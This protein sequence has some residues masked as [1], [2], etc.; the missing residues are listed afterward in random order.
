MIQP[1]CVVCAL[2]CAPA[3]AEAD[4]R[5][6]VS[7]SSPGGELRPELLASLDELLSRKSVRRVDAV[8]VPRSCVVHVRLRLVSAPYAVTIHA[9]SVPPDGREVERRVEREP[10]P[11]VFEE[12]L[13][14]ALY[15]SLS[16]WLERVAAP[17]PRALG[18]RA[19]GVLGASWL[20]T[21]VPDANLLGGLA[22]V[23][24]RAH[25]P[26]LGLRAGASLPHDT[27]RADAATRHAAVKLRLAAGGLLL[28]RARLSL[29]GLGTLGLD[30]LSVR[31][32]HADDFSAVRPSTRALWS[33]G[34]LLGVQVGLGERT[35]LGVELGLTLAIQRFRYVREGDIGERVFM[36]TP[37]A[38]PFLQ[39]VLGFDALR[40]QAAPG[41]TP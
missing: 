13:A 39:L 1:L 24:A 29:R 18:L 4:A 6:C 38:L 23:S 35:S 36:S 33:A 20:T 40:V 30:V 9:E 3:R 5:P 7:L 37:R 10:E 31:A 26:E 32:Q 17:S 19:E 14:H 27:G 11:L 41:G 2:A 21:A 22:L 28:A 15:G 12:T 25:A 34:A 8:D 16:P